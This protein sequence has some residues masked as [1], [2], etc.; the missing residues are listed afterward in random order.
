[1]PQFLPSSN[2]HP[3]GRVDGVSASVS[4]AGDKVPAG[5]C[6]PTWSRW[7]AGVPASM[8]VE[9]RKGRVAAV[10]IREVLEKTLSEPWMCFTRRSG[11][12]IRRLANKITGGSFLLRGE[13]ARRGTVSKRRPFTKKHFDLGSLSTSTPG[14]LGVDGDLR[15]RL[16]NS[17][18]SRSMINSLTGPP[19]PQHRSAIASR[20]CSTQ[21][22][23]RESLKPTT[24]SPLP[25]LARLIVAGGLQRPKFSRQND[26]KVGGDE[27]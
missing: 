3:H 20:L 24:P 1:M 9:I 11:R 18:V 12:S 5:S 21:R 13:W 19:I 25:Q 4:S 8:A 23:V 15:P 22:L 17:P 6:L 16:A 26:I 7:L 10:W 2:R 14:S 27:R